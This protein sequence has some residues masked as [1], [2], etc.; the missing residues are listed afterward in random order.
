MASEIEN[1]CSSVCM[2]TFLGL[3]KQLFPT[4]PAFV[5][6]YAMLDVPGVHVFM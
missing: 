5:N 6:G 3:C 4:L 2:A 1:T